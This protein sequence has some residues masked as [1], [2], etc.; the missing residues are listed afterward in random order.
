VDRIDW[1]CITTDPYGDLLANL[2]DEASRSMDDTPYS[3]V[4]IV[5]GVTSCGSTD[6]SGGQIRDF[7]VDPV[8]SQSAYLFL[9]ACGL[10]G[11]IPFGC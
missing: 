7:L 6:E 9:G 2:S 4:G 5:G 8:W 11:F 10:A 3:P 1:N